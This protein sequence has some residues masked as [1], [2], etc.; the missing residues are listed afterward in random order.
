V[1]HPDELRLT[2]RQVAEWIAYDHIEPLSLGFRID[3]GAAMV[4]HVIANVNRDPKTKSEPFTLDEF[5]IRWDLQNQDIEEKA[6]PTPEDLMLKAA[7]W[8]MLGVGEMQDEGA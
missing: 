8:A 7:A 3:A 2:S 5:L 1:Q 6:A 4:A